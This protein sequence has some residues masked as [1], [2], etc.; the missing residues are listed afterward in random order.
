VCINLKHSLDIGKKRVF[1][2]NVAR[3]IV[4]VRETPKGVSP[5]AYRK[6]LARPGDDP[7][8]EKEHRGKSEAFRSLGFSM[9]L[10]IVEQASRL[11]KTAN[12]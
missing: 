8:E 5:G 12:P 11:V 7:N 9:S 4:T 10:G 1:P 3:G 6:P 2:A